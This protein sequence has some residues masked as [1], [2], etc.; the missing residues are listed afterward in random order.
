MGNGRNEN[1]T[2]FGTKVDE[3]IQRL[4]KSEKEVL[5][6][7]ILQAIPC[8]FICDPDIDFERGKMFGWTLH[9]METLKAI[10]R[11]LS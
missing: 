10:E 3:F 2:F 11:L 9:N 7:E 6:N 8:E 1:M 5:L 4:S